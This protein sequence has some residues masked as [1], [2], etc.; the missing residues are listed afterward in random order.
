MES[1]PP[2][3]PNIEVPTKKLLRIDGAQTVSVVQFG[4][5]THGTTLAMRYA[6]S[7]TVYKTILV[8]LIPSMSVA[9]VSKSSILCSLCFNFNSK[10]PNNSS[11]T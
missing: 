10:R 6:S 8:A 11:T 3:L 4:L 9:P 2:M 1:S 5:V 7:L